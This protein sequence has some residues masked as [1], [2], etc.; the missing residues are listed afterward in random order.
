MSILN[1][2]EHYPVL[3]L[4]KSIHAYTLPDICELVTLDIYHISFYTNKVKNDRRWNDTVNR[5]HKH[6]AYRLWKHHY[7]NRNDDEK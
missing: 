4:Y 3:F 1:H 2:I 5:S 7:Y 6:R